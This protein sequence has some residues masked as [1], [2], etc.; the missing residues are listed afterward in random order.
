MNIIADFI[1]NNH[2]VFY[3]KADSWRDAI[4][5]AC[6]PI[7]ADG[8]V[9]KEYADNIVECVSKYGPYIVLM[10]GIAMPHS[11]E[12]G[13]LVHKTC[14]SFMKLKE[15]VSFD[16]SDPEKYAD[17]FFTLAS[18]NAEKHLAEMT[19]LA[20]LLMNEEIVEE[21]HKVTSGEDLIALRDKYAKIG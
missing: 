12:G 21:L 2:Y 20:E 13:S 15:P 9:E 18:E 1:E 6:E 10:P 17:I 7:I 16:D 5:K 8:T 3:D 11:T 4:Y 14:I 19:M